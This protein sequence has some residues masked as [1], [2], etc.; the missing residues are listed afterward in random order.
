M[1]NRDKNGGGDA[2]TGLG[3]KKT[4]G[5]RQE[6]VY[7]GLD[8]SNQLRFL[9]F[10]QCEREINETWCAALFVQQVGSCSLEQLPRKT[11]PSHTEDVDMAKT[12]PER[13]A[14]SVFVFRLRDQTM[15]SWLSSTQVHREITIHCRQQLAEN[16]AGKQRCG[17]CLCTRHTFVS[18]H[19]SLPVRSFALSLFVFGFCPNSRQ[20]IYVKSN[21]RVPWEISH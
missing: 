2:N 4:T 1:Q 10:L 9:F 21:S 18:K 11:K 8:H 5:E 13:R 19:I 12:F 15:L 7:F 16:A 17:A 3:K 14:A 20:I 6:K